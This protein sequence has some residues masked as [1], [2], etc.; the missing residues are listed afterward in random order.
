M[1]AS[2]GSIHPP[3]GTEEMLFS[4]KMSIFQAEGIAFVN[5]LRI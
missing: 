5:S 2:L 1:G 4:W 3:G